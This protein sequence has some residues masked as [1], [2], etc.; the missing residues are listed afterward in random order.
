MPRRG[1]WA[2]VASVAALLLLQGLAGAQPPPD[3]LFSIL[4]SAPPV[5]RAHASKLIAERYPLLPDEILRIIGRA[6]PMFL[7][8]VRPELE[9]LVDEKYPDLPGFIEAQLRA[10][11]AV[12]AAMDELIAAKYPD[13]IA[14]MKALPPGPDL[15]QRAAALVRAR[16]PELMQDVLVML[17][18]R[19]PAFLIEAQAKTQARFPTLLA[20]AGCLIL[21]KYPQLSPEIMTLVH[22][23][24]PDLVP[25]LMQLIA[26]PPA[27]MPDGT[28]PPGETSQP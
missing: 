28:P 8:E 21:S 17:R 22:A 5:V 3:P 10:A 13:L 20:D 16:Y 19:H 26:N 9:R 4:Q 15:A 25:R 23:K 6:R 24:Y 14:E 18:E 12:Q 27:T 2:I 11:P 1:C 7:A